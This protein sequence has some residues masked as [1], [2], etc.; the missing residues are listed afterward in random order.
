MSPIRA[1]AMI[2]A[3]L[4][5][6]AGG[7]S[8][9]DRILRDAA[10][11]AAG[12][13]AGVAAGQQVGKGISPIFGKV[14]AATAKAAAVGGV[15]K[16]PVILEADPGHTP[17]ASELPDGAV[18]P[19]QRARPQPAQR[20]AIPSPAP[21]PR[22]AVQPDFLAPAFSAPPAPM[23]TKEDLAGVDT[24]IEREQLLAALGRPS[25]RVIIPEDGQ[26]RELYLFSGSGMHLGTVELTDGSVSAINVSRF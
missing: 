6:C 16:T 15:H 18:A 22:P 7:L 23:I 9:Q 21:R 25:A 5:L 13:T 19:P 4:V 20:A 1:F 10:A 26:L 17:T 14:S 3:I 12:G 24:G 2:L 11:A 8:G